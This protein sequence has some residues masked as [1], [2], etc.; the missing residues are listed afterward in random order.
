MSAR[1]ITVYAQTEQA[2]S[3]KCR[4]LKGQLFNY[5]TESIMVRLAITRL[6]NQN[7]IRNQT[8][9]GFIVRK[10]IINEGDLLLA[11]FEI[12]EESSKAGIDIR[13]RN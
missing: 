4:T 12:N 9:D 1:E 7:K 10:G 5:S 11:M 8:I 13:K 2:I 6:F 3:F